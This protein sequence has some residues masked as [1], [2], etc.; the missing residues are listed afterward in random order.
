MLCSQLA[1]LEGQVAGQ[2][3]EL[4]ELTAMKQVRVVVVVEVVVP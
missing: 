4:R 1:S 3:E 2:A